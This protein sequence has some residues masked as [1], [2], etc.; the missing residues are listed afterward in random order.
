MDLKFKGLISDINIDVHEKLCENHYVEYVTVYY[1][2]FNWCSDLNN[3]KRLLICLVAAV[4]KEPLKPNFDNVN[5]RG[6]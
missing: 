1:V 2:L 4:L 5:S 3:S 6:W